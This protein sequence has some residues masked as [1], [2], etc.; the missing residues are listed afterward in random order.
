DALGLAGVLEA[1]KKGLEKVISTMGIHELRG[2][3]RIFSA[4]GLKPEL[5]EYFGTRNFLGS[6]KA[7]YGFLELER[8]LLER[9]GFLRAE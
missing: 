7:G 1:L 3:G 9:E 6:E 2:Y 8:T 4:I 5:A